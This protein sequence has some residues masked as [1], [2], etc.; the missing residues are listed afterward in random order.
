[1]GIAGVFFYDFPMASSSLN[2]MRSAYSL[3]NSLMGILLILAGIIQISMDTPPLTFF[4]LLGLGVLSQVTMTSFVEG[5][6]GVSVSSAISLTTASLYGPI[7][8]ALVAATAEIGL[9]GMRNYGK[10]EALAKDWRKEA[11]LLGVNVGMNSI[12]AVMAGLTLQGLATLLE[13]YPLASLTIPWIVGAIVGDQINLWLLI[14]IIF[15]A[16]GVRPLDVWRENSWA[17][18]INVLVMSAGGGLLASA[19]REFDLLGVAIFFLPILLSAYS[20]RLTVRNS[21]KQMENLEEIVALRTR[22]L[23]DANDQLAETNQQ[24]EQT[25]TQLA[26][27]NSQLAEA[28]N[29]LESAND[30]LK[31]LHMDKNAFLAVLTHD[32]RTPLTS[33]KGYASI[34]HTRELDRAQQKKISKVILNSQD[35]L[36]E[37]VNNILEIEKYQSGTPIEL[38]CELFDL[39]LLAKT[40]VESIAASAHE[41]KI[42]LHYDEV[43]D[44]VMVM[45]DH[46]KIQ[47]ILL[48][49]ISNAVKY[50]PEGGDV[51][52][53]AR[54]NGRYAIFSVQDTG[55]GIPE[56]ELP[57]IFDRY[58]RVKGHQHVAIG[59]GLGLAIVKSLVE[60]HHGEISVTSEVDVGSTFRIKLPL[61][62]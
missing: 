12:A 20:F 42:A 43:P 28:N 27:A 30:E 16:H 57:T 62:N 59:T 53:E 29:Q 51:H 25:N 49:L 31:T 34:L 26:T 17:I 38:D 5:N 56:D 54:G 1:M 22:A 52:V 18:P 32:M 14:F 40:A 35:T 60:A 11:E 9:W 2:R 46:S 45:A 24:M 15:L 55:Y 47:R 21:K 44:P 58:S 48:N 37:I 61:A 39:A 8:A 33:I 41:K 50:T 6:A 36:L 10:R 3:F 7:P 13:G 4:L 19:V 23:A